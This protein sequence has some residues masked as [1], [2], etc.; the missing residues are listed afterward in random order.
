MKKGFTLIELLVVVLVIGIL[1][2]MAIREYQ[3]S[4][5][6]AEA[7]EASLLIAGVRDAMIDYGSEFGHCP[8]TISEWGIPIAPSALEFYNYEASGKCAIVITPKSSKGLK[9]KLFIGA[10]ADGLPDFLFCSGSDCDVFSSFGCMATEDV[11]GAKSTCKDFM[12]VK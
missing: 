4:V 8:D 10:D 12:G 2:G 11:E 9:A 1:S 5:H 3:R 6:R 7:A